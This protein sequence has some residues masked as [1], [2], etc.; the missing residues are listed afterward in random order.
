[1]MAEP[2][3]IGDDRYQSQRLIP[4]WNQDR[5][6]RARVL[7]VGA[8]AIGNEVLKN[9]ALLGIGHLTI[10]D[11][12]VVETMNLSRSIL[13]RPGDQG[14]SKAE[15]AAERLATIN[16]DGQV[17][18]IHGN[19][20]GDVGMGRIAEADIVLGCV[21]NREARLAIN[22]FCWR[23]DRPWI[24]SAIHELSGV[25]QAFAARS[26]PCYECGMKEM[27]YRLLNVRHPCPG[28]IGEP[29]PTGSLPTTPTVSAIIAGWMVQWCLKH[30]HDQPIP[31]GEA[32]VISGQ[33]DQSYR[34]RLPSR[35]DCL[36]H[37]AWNVD[38]AIDG[39][40]HQN[41][42]DQLSAIV[43]RR[44]PSDRP[45]RDHHQRDRW[46]LLL[47]RPLITALRCQNCDFTESLQ[48]AIPS[49]DLRQV[50]AVDWRC[51]KC[52]GRRHGVLLQDVE[53]D[54]DWST[55]RLCELG[56]PDRDWIQVACENQTK[57]LALAGLKTIPCH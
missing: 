13:F 2:L 50:H 40:T 49:A 30:L 52:S 10:V 23:V 16:P 9:L 24:D 45:H 11:M 47:D 33:A 19:L 41:T 12:D 35:D 21:D 57:T 34:T 4:W 7:V 6:A 25:V 17:V 14:R 3:R 51:P 8:G 27:D 29:I 1:M 5:L 55:M 18:A 54:S 37:E 20:L 43:S 36:S 56:I 26:A 53:L 48:P 46:R 28:G 22:R 32:M 39:F 15:L 31:W 42:I 38:W 44:W